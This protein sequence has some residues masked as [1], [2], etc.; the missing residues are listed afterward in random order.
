MPLAYSL[1]GSYST[2][3]VLAANQVNDVVYCTIQT[4]PSG[5]VASVPIDQIEFAVNQSVPL[6]EATAEAIET[7]MGD[8]RVIAGTGTQAL[9]QSNLLQDYVVF[10]VQ[11][12]PT[13]TT[14]TN[15]TANATVPITLLN[16][17]EEPRDQL[18]AAQVQ[19]MIDDV[20]ANLQSA[21]GG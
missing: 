9:D 4:I 1:L 7:I 14:G 17:S 8:S 2:V 18:H 12:I 20:Y 11:Y 16:F 19:Q 10:T 5:V 13:G 3:Q 21:A 6:L 15:I